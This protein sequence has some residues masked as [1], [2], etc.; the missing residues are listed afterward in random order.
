MDQLTI[1]TPKLNVV[2]TEKGERWGGGE[3][4]QREG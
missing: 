4:N 1:K 2:L 3:L